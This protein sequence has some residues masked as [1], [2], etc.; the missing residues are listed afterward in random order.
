MS[1]TDYLRT[2]HPSNT[3]QLGILTEYGKNRFLLRLP[4]QTL[5]SESL[6]SQ[7]KEFKVSEQKDFWL[8]VDTE[9]IVYG[10]TKI[11]AKE[12]TINGENI[13]L[14]KEGRFRLHMALPMG[15]SP[16]CSGHF[17]RWTQHRSVTPVVT[18]RIE[19]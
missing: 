7:V 3:A 13:Q 9:L 14:D 6:S 17:V 1:C 4:L 19:N 12:L 10:Q 11:S 5:S 15:R 8:W 18:R 16:S 2:P